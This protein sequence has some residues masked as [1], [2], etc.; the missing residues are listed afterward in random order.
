MV[1]CICLTGV[2]KAVVGAMLDNGHLGNI[3]EF[4]NGYYSLGD[5][6]G[7]NVV[8]ADGFQY[9][10]RGPAAAAAQ[11]LLDFPAIRFALLVGIGS[12]VPDLSGKSP[13]IR[14]GDVAVSDLTNPHGG[15][16]EFDTDESYIGRFTPAAHHLNKTSRFLQSTIDKVVADH[17]ILR[18]LPVQSSGK[19]GN[20]V[21][22]YS[23]PG[24]WNDL[25]FSKDCLHSGGETCRNC[26]KDQ[27]IMRQE[28]QSMKPHI[29]YGTIV[30]AKAVVRDT[31]LR[32][33]MQLERD[34]ICIET[35]AAGIMNCFPCLVICGIC[36][37]ADSHSNERW[38]SYASL[39]AVAYMTE[40]LHN[41]SPQQVRT[42][43]P[44]RDI[45][46]EGKHSITVYAVNF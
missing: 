11:L 36:D 26:D 16:L 38:Q 44:P 25:L 39:A 18:I 7:H 40:L 42:L 4:H 34:S 29:H 31:D 28:R 45:E 15:I 24:A 20:L 21:K 17:R 5:V 3:A 14:L 43:S 41:I 33:R 1:A 27:L 46:I 32:E 30:S 23:Y 6:G 35:E 37:Y 10:S 2:S 13:D 22:D 12:G 19:W 8:I 9:H